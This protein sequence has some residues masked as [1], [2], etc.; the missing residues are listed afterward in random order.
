M[1]LLDRFKKITTIAL[2]VDGVLTD[3]TLLLLEDGQ[4]ARRMNI[5]D[6]YA[7][8]LAVKKGYRLLIISGGQSEAVRER[9]QKLG[10][11]D[12][13]IRAENKTAILENYRQQYSLEWEEILFMGDDIPD[14]AA[15][16]LV[17]L[18]C[19]PADAAAEIKQLSAYISPYK[20]GEGCVRDIL[21]KIMKLRGDWQID[22]TVSSK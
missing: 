9:L 7:L 3:G 5:K 4:M 12:V 11:R 18:P 6:G 15:M 10:I 19:A 22:T 21:E 14:F 17:G 1:S 2:D 16:Q 8:Q 20:G 13:F